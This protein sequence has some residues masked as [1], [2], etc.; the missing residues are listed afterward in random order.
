MA[1]ADTPKGSNDPQLRTAARSTRVYRYLGV[2]A[3]AFSII[4]GLSSRAPNASQFVPYLLIGAV[5]L[6]FFILLDLGLGLSSRIAQILF[7]FLML[8]LCILAIL[9]YW[10]VHD[11]E[12]A[13]LVGRPRPE[14]TQLP[15]RPAITEPAVTTPATPGP[16]QIAP[17]PTERAVQIVALQPGGY[18]LTPVPGCQPSGEATCA[19]P[20]VTIPDGVTVQR[21]VGIMGEG[22]PPPSGAPMNECQISGGDCP[23][24]WSS[25]QVTTAN[26]QQVCV[27]AKNWSHN[28]LRYGGVVVEY[29]RS[30]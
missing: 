26:A 27:L 23:I 30:H 3:V 6:P 4:L 7:T 18:A 16:A 29:Q 9:T 14:S 15:G 10:M 17:A 12:F 11:P 19:T 8:A 1:D 24:G 28:R 13:R 22:P 5:S 20:C 25:I 21:T 2:I